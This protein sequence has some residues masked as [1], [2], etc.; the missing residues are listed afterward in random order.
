MFE[1]GR[2]LKIG[3]CV[4]FFIQNESSMP[5]FLQKI[6]L[7]F[8]KYHCKGKN[9]SAFIEM[10]LQRRQVMLQNYTA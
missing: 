8:K 4:D 6:C 10:Y 2:V 3:F 1:K 5:S 7:K 9:I